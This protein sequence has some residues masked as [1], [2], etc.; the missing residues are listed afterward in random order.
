MPQQQVYSAQEVDFGN[1]IKMF[2]AQG[3]AGDGSLVP[4][5]HTL[6]ITTLTINYFRSRPQE[7]WEGSTSPDGTPPGLEPAQLCG[8]FGQ[9]TRSPRRLPISRFPRL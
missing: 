8:D 5:S 6:E 7:H 1:Y 3:F 9:S 2:W 4:A